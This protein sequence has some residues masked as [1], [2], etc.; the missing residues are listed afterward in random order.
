MTLVTAVDAASAFNA[1]ADGYFIF[2]NDGVDAGKV[3]WDEN[4]GSG[5]DAVAIAE[6]LGVT[7]L[8]LSDFILA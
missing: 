6:L 1:G 2:D 4:G 7:S 3:Y 8:L 5:A